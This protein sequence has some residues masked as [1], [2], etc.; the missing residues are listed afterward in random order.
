MFEAIHGTALG[1]ALAIGF[2]CSAATVLYVYAGYPL[3]IWLASRLLGEDSALDAE[4][5]PLPTVSVIIAAHNEESVI[6]ARLEN[7]LALDYPAD[8]L[9][10]LIASD[11][12]SD[13]TCE[14]VASCT[15]ERVRLLNFPTNRGKSAVLAEAVAAA[16]GDVLALSDANTFMDPQALRHLVRR[17]ADPAVGVVC[18]RLVLIDP[19]SGRNVDGVYWRYETFLKLC[20]TRLNALLGANG[21][22]YAIRRSLF[23]ELPSR[24]AVDDFVIPLL[25]RLRSGASIAYESKATA[26]E[27]TPP[28]I[29]A[30]FGRRSRIG[31]GGFQS[32][33][34]LYPLLNPARG[35]VFF[36]FASH[37][38]LRWTCPF[39]LLTLALTNF[40]L[41][42][43]AFYGWA[44]LAQTM[45][46]GLAI[47]GAFLP[48]PGQMARFARLATMF[49]A[50]NLALLAGFYRWV[51]GSQTGVWQ[52]TART[53]HL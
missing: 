16:R 10:I 13:R 19:V 47:A 3:L 45:L 37:K 25:A 41:V 30:E 51:S 43:S 44:M 11:G 9:E 38:L 52:R 34:L 4:C 46:Y 5:S 24:V 12:S 17:F 33:P 28:D 32:L 39:F 42:D 21:A 29:R 7:L 20:E 31:A 50:M 15:S 2:W 18:G 14:I 8:R 40:L 6:A 27:E 48:G 23:P 53:S 36:S 22:I 26:T 1:S 49:T 35:W